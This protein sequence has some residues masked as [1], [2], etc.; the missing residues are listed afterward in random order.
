MKNK[1]LLLLPLLLITA[2]QCMEQSIVCKPKTIQDIRNDR[3]AI[4][5]ERLYNRATYISPLDD[6][7][8]QEHW[9]YHL[10]T[11]KKAQTKEPLSLNHNDD[12]F[13][14]IYNINWYKTFNFNNY[15][16]LG[17]A[18]IAIKS[19]REPTDNIFSDGERNQKLLNKE[20]PIQVPFE[21]KKEHIQKLFSFGFE[22]TS[23]DKYFASLEKWERCN[24]LLMV[25][26][27]CSLLKSP[28]LSEMNVPQEIIKFITLLM[29]ET[30]ESLL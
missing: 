12:N 6:I 29:W 16:F 7:F 10:T 18:T 13:G 21:Q 24:A 30:E 5:R 23:Q 8:F 11:L 20:N 26:R 3:N 1:N 25:K 14:L 17:L 4:Y 22:P 2:T 28:L 9:S 27:M 19:E 15:S